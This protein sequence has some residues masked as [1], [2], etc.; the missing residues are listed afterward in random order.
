MEWNAKNPN[1]V[2][3]LITFKLQ[4]KL[5]LLHSWVE[6]DNVMH[7]MSVDIYVYFPNAVY[8]HIY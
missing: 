4:I 7:S 8:I 1:D 5:I 3:S 6:S 2:S